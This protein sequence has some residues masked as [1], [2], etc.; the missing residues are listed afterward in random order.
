MLARVVGRSSLPLAAFSEKLQLL[1]PV[2]IFSYSG[3]ICERR[4]VCLS[5]VSGVSGD[6]NAA[7]AGG[8]GGSLPRSGLQLGA[9][10]QLS[11][12]LHQA[13][14]LRI[15]VFCF[16]CLFTSDSRLFLFREAIK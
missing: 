12:G 1:F 16:P 15:S 7:A 4:A 11:L 14:Y 9:R 8:T 6:R 13:R 3:L 10:V 5:V 2:R